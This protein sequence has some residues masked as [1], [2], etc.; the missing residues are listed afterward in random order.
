MNIAS[1]NEILFSF[2]GQKIVEKHTMF[3]IM[4]NRR[5]LVIIM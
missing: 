5:Y 1:F 3:N 2:E 4:W